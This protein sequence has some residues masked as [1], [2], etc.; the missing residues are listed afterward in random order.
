MCLTHRPLLQ[1]DSKYSQMNC[2]FQ[3]QSNFLCFLTIFGKKR[4]KFGN[5]LKKT[6]HV[7]VLAITLLKCLCSQ[8]CLRLYFMKRMGTSIN[9]A[10]ITLVSLLD[11][12]NSLYVKVQKLHAFEL[13]CLCILPYDG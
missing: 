4:Q 1:L 11:N 2:F 9:N 10:L 8:T 3:K 5:F 7:R 13:S 6:T 12:P